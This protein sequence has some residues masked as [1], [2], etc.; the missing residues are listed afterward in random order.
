[1]RAR[2]FALGSL[3]GLAPMTVVHVY[4]GTT[5]STAAALISGKAKMSGPLAWTALAA[6]FV[7]TIFGIFMLVRIGRRALA[8]ALIEADPTT[9]AAEPPAPTATT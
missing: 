2:D 3:I 7:A 5:V 6:G 4:L 8:R 1:M 9:R